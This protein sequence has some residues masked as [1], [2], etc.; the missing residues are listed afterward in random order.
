MSTGADKRQVSVKVEI[1]FFGTMNSV[2]QPLLDAFECHWIVV[3]LELID[4][5]LLASDEVV[6]VTDP[7]D[8]DQPTPEAVTICLSVPLDVDS[9]KRL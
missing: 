7:Q 6:E 5:E 3:D 8:A 1:E 2:L 4:K 9:E